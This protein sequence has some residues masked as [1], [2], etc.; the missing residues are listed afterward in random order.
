MARV[1]DRL[2]RDKD[3]NDISDFVRSFGQHD[4]EAGRLLMRAFDIRLLRGRLGTNLV[5]FD[6]HISAMEA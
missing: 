4:I 2:D 5:E 6:G 1:A 3:P